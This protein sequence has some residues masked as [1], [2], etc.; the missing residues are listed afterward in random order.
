MADLVFEEIIHSADPPFN[1]NQGKVL[2]GIKILSQNVNTLNLST[3]FNP[4]DKVKFH[5]KILAVLKGGADIICIQDVRL[6]DHSEHFKNQFKL[7]SQGSYECYMNSDKAERGNN[8][9]KIIP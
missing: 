1:T 7:H 5:K 9:D 6:G 4:R 2:T 8:N 3:L